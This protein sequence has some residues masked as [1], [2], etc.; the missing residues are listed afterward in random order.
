MLTTAPKGTR[1][2]LPGESRELRARFLGDVDLSSASLAL[3]GWNVKAQGLT[4]AK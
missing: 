3:Q 2:I 1:D 4:L